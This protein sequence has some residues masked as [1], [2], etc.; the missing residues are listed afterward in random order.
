[1]KYFMLK[2]KNS[3]LE[4]VSILKGQSIWMEKISPSKLHTAKKGLKGF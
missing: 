2:S 4:V 3:K 1:M